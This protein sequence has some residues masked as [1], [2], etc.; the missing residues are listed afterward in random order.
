MEEAAEAQ[1]R[2]VISPSTSSEERSEPKSECRCDHK[3]SGYRA[4]A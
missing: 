3:V 4:S 1:R 2:W